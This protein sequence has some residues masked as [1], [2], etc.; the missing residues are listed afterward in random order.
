MHITLNKRE[1]GQTW[2][3]PILG[4]GQL[5]AYSTDL[6]QKRLM[7]QRFQEEVRFTFNVIFFV[8][9]DSEVD[10]FAFYDVFSICFSTSVVWNL[11]LILFCLT[12][13]LFVRDDIH[14]LYPFFFNKLDQDTRKQSFFYCDIEL[15]FIF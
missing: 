8:W 15:Y 12:S 9:W 3:S 14:I 13:T 10:Q 4:Q 7:L 6:E 5:D 2:P 11:I 1:K